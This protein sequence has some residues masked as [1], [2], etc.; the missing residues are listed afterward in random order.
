MGLCGVDQLPWSR[1]I[2]QKVLQLYGYLHVGIAAVLTG[3]V[4]LPSSAT[5]LQGTL[6]GVR[7]WMEARQRPA[8][9]QV[10]G[11]AVRQYTIRQD[12]ATAHSS[13]SL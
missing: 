8:R 2:L 7:R 5:C 4:L 9:R 11:T 3:P 1:L 10:G 6:R 12:I 13:R